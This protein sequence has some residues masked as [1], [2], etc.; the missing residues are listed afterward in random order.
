M[1]GGAFSVSTPS[2]YKSLSKS[3]IFLSVKQE[4]TFSQPTSSAQQ[5]K[6]SAKLLYVQNTVKII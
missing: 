1:V 3:R 4:N 5:V 2:L 6:G